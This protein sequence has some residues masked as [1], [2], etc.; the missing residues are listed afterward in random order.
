MK[1]GKPGLLKALMEKLGV[2]VC[3]CSPSTGEAE[4][5]RSQKHTSQSA[6]SNGGGLE[7]FSERP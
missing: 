5:C 4:M 6:S 7:V 3:A 2:V 1:P